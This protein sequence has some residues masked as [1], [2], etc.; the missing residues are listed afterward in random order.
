MNYLEKP[1]FRMVNKPK[2]KKWYSVFAHFE[3]DGDIERAK[4]RHPG[5]AYRYA[6]YLLDNHDTYAEPLIEVRVEC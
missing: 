1:K 6:T 5:D 2:R 3:F 4:F